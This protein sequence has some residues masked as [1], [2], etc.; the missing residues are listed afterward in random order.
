MNISA[1]VLTAK[2]LQYYWMPFIEDVSAE[3][4]APNEVEDVFYE[5]CQND[6]SRCGWE[7]RNWDGLPVPRFEPG[8]TLQ[9]FYKAEYEFD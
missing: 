7:V 4:E 1:R 8:S 5:D 2:T 3:F 6:S 9:A